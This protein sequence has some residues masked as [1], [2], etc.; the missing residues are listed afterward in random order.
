[1]KSKSAGLVVRNGILV[2]KDTDKIQVKSIDKRGNS[3]FTEE[4][5]EVERPLTQ[6]AMDE[7]M[8]K[9][10]K[11]LELAG[12]S[13][14]DV[15]SKANPRLMVRKY[16]NLVFL[17][18]EGDDVLYPNV[19]VMLAGLNP[20]NADALIRAIRVELGEPLRAPYGVSGSPGKRAFPVQRPAYPEDERQVDQAPAF[21][22]WEM[23][24]DI[25]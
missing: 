21:G 9:Y 3:V 4:E 19:S 16:E 8:E 20:L 6:R 5:K 15:Q 13:F 1:M 12:A 24:W 14:E 11:A 2:L 18:A 25:A 22:G 17:S 10:L 23:P 7:K